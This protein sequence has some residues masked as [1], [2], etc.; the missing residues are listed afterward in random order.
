M[1]ASDGIQALPD[2]LIPLSEVADA[3]GGISIRTVWRLVAAGELP[4]PVRVGRE[5]A[6]FSSEV[7]AYLSKLKAGRKTECPA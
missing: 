4:K 6:L 3:L 1:K 2:K 7:R 5:A